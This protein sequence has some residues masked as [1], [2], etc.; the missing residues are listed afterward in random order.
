MVS[1]SV[2]GKLESM[3]PDSINKILQ[4]L[5]LI[6][7]QKQLSKDIFQKIIDFVIYFFQCTKII[8]FL[9]LKRKKCFTFRWHPMCE[10]FN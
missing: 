4:A 9:A 3:N 7:K 5:S 8:V 2:I 6:K 1:E 10:T